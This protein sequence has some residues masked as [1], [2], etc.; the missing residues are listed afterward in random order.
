MPSICLRKNG[1]N[2]RAMPKLAEKLEA[3]Y[4]QAVLNWMREDI[5]A[6]KLELRKHPNT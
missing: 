3:L 1:W 5:E 4:F 6:R 2:G